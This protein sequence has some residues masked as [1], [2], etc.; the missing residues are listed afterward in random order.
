MMKS[1]AQDLWNLPHVIFL[2]VQYELLRHVFVLKLWFEIMLLVWFDL[3]F[4]IVFCWCDLNYHL[5]MC[6]V[7]V[8]WT[9]IV[10]GFIFEGKILHTWYYWMG[11]AGP[12][13][14][15]PGAVRPGAADTLG[16]G[17]SYSTYVHVVRWCD[18]MFHCGWFIFEGNI[19]HITNKMILLDRCSGAWCNAAWCNT[20]WCSI[21]F[22][23]QY[24]L[25]IWIVPIL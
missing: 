4:A 9:F 22:R 18:L 20:A 10:G 25:Y 8:I 1:A 6:F 21:Y 19:L 14:T 23:L 24:L 11:A 13:A 2:L 15:R 7:G 5:Q 17:T 16:L 12:G 3:S